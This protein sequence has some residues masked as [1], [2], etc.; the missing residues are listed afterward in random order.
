MTL[1]GM[2]KLQFSCLSFAQAMT[3]SHKN[4]MSF[5]P[6]KTTLTIMKQNKLW[7]ML[8]FKYI[9]E[10]LEREVTDNDVRW[11]L[12]CIDAVDHVKTLR[13]T[14]CYSV[15]GVGL[16]PLVGS[17]VLEKIDLSLVGNHEKPTINTKHIISADLVMPML[18]RMISNEGSS[19]LIVHL[20]K[21][22]RLERVALLDGFYRR[23]NRELNRRQ[24]ECGGNCA[25]LNKGFVVDQERLVYL[26]NGLNFYGTNEVTCYGCLRSFCS[27][28][29]DIHEV[30]FCDACE[31][32]YCY[33]CS[34]VMYSECCDWR[35]C[36]DCGEIKHW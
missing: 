35:S 28:C 8:D 6:S 33:N 23:F 26:D 3:H 19:L 2:K 31:R 36:A 25:C 12:Q 4:I 7:E 22:W 34:Y 18:D 15:T 21:K 17:T 13:L 27:S 9:A 10:Y 11:L 32:M 29:I 14:H 24:V 1:E 5:Q 16:Q 30:N 20:P